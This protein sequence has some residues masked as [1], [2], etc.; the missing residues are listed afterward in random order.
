MTRSD[1]TPEFPLP[2]G[3]GGYPPC[4]GDGGLTHKAD[5][6]DSANDRRN[7]YL[8]G[9]SGTGKS[10]SGRITAEKLGMKFVDTDELIEQKSGKPIP[11][12][13]EEDGEAKFRDI[14]SATLA[15]AAASVNTV[16]ST[17]GGMPMRPEN[18]ELMSRTGL[19]I[20]LKASPES[21]NT[22]LTRSEGARGR[23][24]RPLL[25]GDAPVEKIRRLLAD[26][27]E[28]YSAAHITID[29]ENKIPRD[30]ANEIIQAWRDI[31]GGG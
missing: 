26:R 1:Q 9:F 20:R 5:T 4:I 6:T 28:A 16:I 14:E 13:F 12:I 10:H 11:E 19:V 8:T 31:T 23:T 29:T 2:M 30:V 25:G 21:I 22:R 15:E 27:E 17:G 3:G 18:R 24:L 7:I